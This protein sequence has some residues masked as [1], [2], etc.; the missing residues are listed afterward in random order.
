MNRKIRS[1]I[2]P[3]LLSVSILSASC[4]SANNVAMSSKG[5]LPNASHHQ[6]TPGSSSKGLPSSAPTN[7]P[8]CSTLVDLGTWST[9]RLASQILVT[10]AFTNS[11]SDADNAVKSGVGGVLLMG[12]PDSS[13]L[14]ANI[15]QLDSLAPR[16]I[17]PFMMT[18]EEGG[19]IQRMAQLVGSM[20]WPRQM[21]E[22]MTP[23]QVESVAYRVGKGLMHLGVNVD[24]AP[25]VDL[26][27][28]SGPS[29]NNP[30]GK[31]S[32]S[33]DPI[34]T[35]RYADAFVTGLKRSGVLPTLKHFPGLGG[36]SG[37]TD[38]MSAHTRPYSQLQESALIPFE[39]LASKVPFIMISNASVP[40]LS[41]GVPASLSPIMISML[42][43]K[44]GFK[45]I[46]ISDSLE[47]TSISDFQ[48]DLSK[49]VLDSVTA[50]VDM[51]MLA[52]INPVQ[53]P[54][55]L[56]AESALSRAISSGA[57]SRPIIE[58]RVGAILALK[59]I[60]TSCISY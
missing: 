25:V 44:V 52:S 19:G 50:G 11:L 5:V 4:S 26:D 15:S 23:S 16:G 60:P 1:S 31:R 39:V 18:D 28:R 13:S 30:D 21:A 54:I 53:S 22:S 33:I 41:K 57:L 59:G 2:I 9:S 42:R 37:N 29:N 40:G 51:I 12:N 10:S 46:I 49:A 17:T 20:P 24:L 45:G 27:N 36:A 58:K 55:F 8:A 7:P 32:F 14:G 43:N 6:A 3:T 34:K 47:T 48:P 56:Q 38:V 35:T